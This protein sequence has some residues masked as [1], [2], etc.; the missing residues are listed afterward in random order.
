MNRSDNTTQDMLM[1]VHCVLTE[2][3]FNNVYFL[4]ALSLM[5]DRRHQ[6]REIEVVIMLAIVTCECEALGHEMKK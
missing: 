2:G 1:F 4:C 6:A 3:L 5:F